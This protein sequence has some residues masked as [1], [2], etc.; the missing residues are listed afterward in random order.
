MPLY[1][2]VSEKGLHGYRMYYE[3]MEDK[4]H[5]EH[6]QFCFGH[7][8]IEK[9]IVHHCNYNK[10]DNTPTNL[11]RV[12]KSEHR[13]IHNNSTVDYTQTAKSLCD[14]Y[15][16]N[17]D[18]EEYKLRTH[19][20]SVTT[21]INNHYRKTGERLSIVEAEAISNKNAVAEK[22]LN[23]RI[24]DIELLFNVEWSALL[25]R[26]RVAYGCKLS[27]VVSKIEQ[28]YS[29]DWSILSDSEKYHYYD[30]Y[31]S[32]RLL[33]SLERAISGSL[34]Q[35]LAK[36]PTKYIG[37]PKHASKS[38]AH[39][40]IRTVASFSPDELRIWWIECLFGIDWSESTPAERGL[41]TRRFNKLLNSGEYIPLDVKIKYIPKPKHIIKSVDLFGSDMD[42]KFKNI[43]ELYGVHMGGIPRNQRSGYCRKYN[44]FCK[45]K[46]NKKL[47]AAKAL[48]R[49]IAEIERIYGVSWKDLDTADKSKYS[50]KYHNLMNP[51][52]KKSHYNAT[53]DAI[54]QHSWYTD[55]VNNMYIKNGDS[56]PDGFRKGRTILES[57]VA[58]GIA[59][60]KNRTP[61]Q[62]AAIAKKLSEDTSRRI[63]IT[64][65]T[66][67]KYIY[68]DTPIPEG[69]R[70]GRCKIGKNH[71]VKSVERIAMPCRV[72][73]LTIKDN[74][75]FA[76]SAGVFVHN[77]VS[78]VPTLANGYNSK[79]IGKDASDSLAGAC[80]SCI[81][82]ADQVKPPP[83][84]VLG[85]M[86]GV[87]RG[88]GYLGGGPTGQIPWMN[89]YKRL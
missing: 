63:W 83:K 78:A 13:R 54:S 16:N 70:L 6:R 60:V 9:N 51:E 77:S 52:E 26:E 11:Q 8:S 85:A 12:S 14:W 82:N 25:G 23:R 59:T 49:R 74:H 71:K 2:K 55:G 40:H 1:T 53:S 18:T 31:I 42:I 62:K 39:R 17:K 86:A 34:N 38:K 36:Y 67:D 20:G 68:R 43:E 21:I 30:I 73:D 37:K 4:W 46:V 35:V 33:V 89:Q 3:P 28:K 27:A 57:S 45:G 69:F 87:N 29:V 80:F 88:I 79:G 50:L 58:K 19:K 76:L 15:V 84:N 10:L 72:Y 5:Y 44:N 7:S 75:N 22:T 48:Q 81:K 47:A 64:N 41:A 61:E 32:D 56:I 24:H 66:V 65:G